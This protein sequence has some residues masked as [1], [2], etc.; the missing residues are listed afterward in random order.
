[1]TDE[2]T[3][4]YM[5][6]RVGQGVRRELQK[7]LTAWE[8]SVPAFTVLSV[9]ERRPRLSNA[10]LARRSMITRQSM[11][12]VMSE[13]EARGLLHRSAD[14]SHGRILRA[15]LTPSG[16]VL[17]R[18]IGPHVDELQ[19][20]LLAHVSADEREIVMRGLAAAMAA[21]VEGHQDR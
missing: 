17:L 2:P 18:K 14:P 8:I 13:L 9:L 11:T 20:R 3:F 19:D 16:R 21:L 10:Q 15:E 5:V 12:L 6:G 7:V 4:V 1:M